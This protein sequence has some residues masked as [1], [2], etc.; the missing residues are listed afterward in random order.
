MK[1]PLFKIFWSEDDI[2][3]VEKVIR[4]GMSWCVGRDI[5]EFENELKEYLGAKYCLSFNSGGSALYA[6]M[7]AYKFGQ[8]D[9]IIVPS[10]T[11]IAT[12]YAPLYVNAKPV[13][14][15]VEDE[16]FSLDPEDVLHRISDRTRAIIPIHYGGMP[17]RIKELK[18]IA[19]DKKIILIEDAAE[20]F[21]AKYRNQ[22]VG[23][24]GDAAI[25]SF[26]HNKVFT[27]SEGGCVVTNN[28]E[29]YE[30]LKLIRSYGRVVKGDYFTNPENLDY[31]A[32]GFNFRMSTLLAALGRAQLRRVDE[33]IRLRRQHAAYLN[34]HLRGIREIKVPEAPSDDYFAVYQ[35]YTIRVLEGSKRREELMTFLKEKGVATRIYFEP[36]H[37]YT[38]FRSMLGGAEVELPV[39]E[40][41]ASE[42][43]TLPLYPGMSKEELDYIIEGIA[44][45]F[46]RA[47]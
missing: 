1:I 12:G 28:K 39:T 44:E 6:L 29:I 14:A 42:V 3:A 30:R 40:R 31:V 9:E 33:S 43:L 8:G 32:V 2:K 10:F 37:R 15:D 16:T 20:S 41:L 7:L 4:S 24:F 46:E 19:E 22:F 18:E 47:R 36:I 27:T 13:F 21:G 17:C 38:V 45:F 5:E 35:M 26:C 25:F 23:T 11:F 34:E